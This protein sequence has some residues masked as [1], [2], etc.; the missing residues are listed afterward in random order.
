MAFDGPAPKI[1]L[2]WDRAFRNAEDDWA[3]EYRVTV[4]SI[5]DSCDARY[6][7]YKTYVRAQTIEEDTWGYALLPFNT[8]T[9]VVEY[10][11]GYANWKLW[12]RRFISTGPGGERC[13]EVLRFDYP[14]TSVASD[15]RSLSDNVARTD[16][17]A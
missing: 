15:L 14:E 10:A 4:C 6:T 16:A 12:S 17:W 7:P 1:T 13:F 5:G 8:Y 11:D 3:D 2:A 9:V